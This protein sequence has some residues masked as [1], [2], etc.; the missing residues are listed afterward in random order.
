MDI[1]IEYILSNYIWILVIAIITLLAIIGW[2]ADKTNFGQGKQT[3]EEKEKSIEDLKNELGD[4]KLL[5]EISGPVETKS[6]EENLQEEKIN[7]TD[8]TSKIEPE[9]SSNDS[10]INFDPMTG[11][12]L[13]S[14]VGVIN[15][16]PIMKFDPMTGEP[17]KIENKDDTQLSKQ[18]NFEVSHKNEI[19]EDNKE[20]TIDKDEFG[21]SFDSF[22]KTFNEIIPKKDI[23]DENLLEEID[24][25]T[26]EKKQK[27]SLEEIPNL[28]DID[29]P[30]IKQI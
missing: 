30:Q 5:D 7:E 29:L 26:F 10:K 4:K 9:V 6:V 14:K 13:D 28:D 19:I 22:D 15:N 24:N 21:H 27:F 11:E 12:P 3:E 1:I 18:N 23:M 8:L 16:E 2:Y 17:I 20:I 25:L